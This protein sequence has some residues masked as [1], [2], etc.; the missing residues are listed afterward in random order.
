MEIGKGAPAMKIGARA[1]GFDRISRNSAASVER[2][3]WLEIQ[4][5]GSMGRPKAGTVLKLPQDGIWGQDRMIT[6]LYSH[7]VI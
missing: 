2:C 3:G 4:K 6:R 1:L 5:S 7:I